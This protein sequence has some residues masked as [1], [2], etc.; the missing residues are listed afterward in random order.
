MTRIGHDGGGFAFDNEGPAH[1]TL[2]GRFHLA[3]RLVTQHEYLAFIRDGGY[4]RPELWLSQGWDRVCAGWRAP[5]YWEGSATTGKSSHCTACR[6][7]SC[8]RLSRT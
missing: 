2:L 1:D 6:N 3:N 5:L 4:S 8:R 7:W